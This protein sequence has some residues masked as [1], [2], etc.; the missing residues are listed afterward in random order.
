MFKSY[1]RPTIWKTDNNVMI[2]AIPEYISYKNDDWSE[3]DYRAS[4]NATII[5]SVA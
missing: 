3:E 5:L 2:T 1:I 4:N